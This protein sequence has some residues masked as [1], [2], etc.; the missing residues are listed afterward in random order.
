MAKRM[1]SN[2]LSKEEMLKLIADWDSSKDVELGKPVW[3]Y[4][5]WSAVQFTHWLKT[6]Q[7]PNV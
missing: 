2:A 5:G 7:Q 3:H 6:G 4:M 1:Y